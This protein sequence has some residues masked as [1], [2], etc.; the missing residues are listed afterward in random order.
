MLCAWTRL[1]S[2]TIPWTSADTPAA[3]LGGDE[4]VNTFRPLASR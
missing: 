1:L 4:V 2:P 3:M